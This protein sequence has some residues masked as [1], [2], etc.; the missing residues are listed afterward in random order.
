MGKPTWVSHTVFCHSATMSNQIIHL[1]ECLKSFSLSIIYASFT[2]LNFVAPPI[3]SLLGTRLSLVLGALTYVLFLAGFLFLNTLFLYF[4][5]ALLGLGAAGLCVI[6]SEIT[7]FGAIYII[8]LTV[9][10]YSNLDCAR[11]IFDAE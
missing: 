6:S 1:R 9:Y 5:S 8:L 11:Q 7:D 3:I 2:V 4:S 10:F